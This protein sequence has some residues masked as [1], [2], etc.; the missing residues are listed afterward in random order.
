M[1]EWLK[2]KKT[3]LTAAAGILGAIAAWSDGAIETAKLV[4]LIWEA[5]LAVFIRAGVGTAKA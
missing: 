3:F 4:E 2:G 5:G 1:R